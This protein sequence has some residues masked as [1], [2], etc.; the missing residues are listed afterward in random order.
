MSA[1]LD[2]YFTL[3]EFQRILPIINVIR[4]LPR[5]ILISTILKTWL[6]LSSLL[7]PFSKPF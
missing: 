5:I 4:V 1:Y 6:I 3:E 2:T 7:L